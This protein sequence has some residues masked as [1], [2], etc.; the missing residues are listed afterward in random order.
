[1]KTLTL[2]LVTFTLAAGAALADVMSGPPA[3][4]ALAP[5]K[6]YAATGPQKEKELDYAA[7]RKEKTTVFLLLRDWDRP[8]GRYLKTLDG[9]IRGASAEAEI[10]AVWLTDRKDETREYLPRAQQSLRLERTSLV[11]FLG[12]A[13]GPDG[14]NVNPDARVT[15]IVASKGKVRK[16]FGYDSINETDAAPV[17]KAVEE[18]VK[19]E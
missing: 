10:V 16:T 11:L 2:P 13:N 7:E 12:D 5:L 4:E 1:M 17:V 6:V 14:W 3:G 8:I 19:A 18:A 9:E 15:T